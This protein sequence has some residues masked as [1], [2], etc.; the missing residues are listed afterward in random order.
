MSSLDASRFD[1][2]TGIA[3]GRSE[4]FEASWR[5]PAKVARLEYGGIR[6]LNLGASLY[7]GHTGYRS[8]GVNPGVTIGEFDGR[9]SFHR[10]DFRGL[11]ADTW[12]SRARELNLRLERELGFNPN[13]ARRMRGYYFEPAV[14]VLPMRTRHDVIPFLRY[15]KYNTQ[16]RMPAGYIPLAQFDRSSWI[17]GITYKPHPDVAVKFDYVFNRNASQV[18][19]AVN[20]VNLGLGWWF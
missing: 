6:R 8:P 10:F 7:S 12:V 17:T 18:V 15:E 2:G 4:G 19:R 1:A 9:Y 5:N 3:E 16:Y 11:F 14:H 13:I 20:G